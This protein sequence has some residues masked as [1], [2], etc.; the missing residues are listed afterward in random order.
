MAE[1]DR[2]SG[3]TKAL[4]VIGSP[5]GHSLSPAMHNLTYQKLGLD[6]VYLAFDV[7]PEQL[8][9]VIPAMK[10]MGFVG[11]NV[12]MPCKTPILP[13]LDELSDAARLMN[14]VN[15]VVI[16]DGRAYGHNTD[17]AGFMRNLKENGIDV[18]GSRITIA[19][20][21]GAGSAILTQAALDGV[22]VIEVF[23]TRDELFEKLK[24]RVAKLAAE[25]GCAI[26]VHDRSDQEALGR[27]VAESSLFV[28]AT[29]TGMGPL[30]D[31]SVL[32]A[33]FLHPDL[34]VADAVYDPP[35]TKMLATAQA[36]GNV[37]ISGLGMLLWQAAIAEELFV[38]AAMPVDYVA[39][40]VFP[41]A[42][43]LSQRRNGPQQDLQ[44]K[45]PAKEATREG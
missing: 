9:T 35:V 38:G 27:C 28:N 18:C 20:A 32:P 16:K 5:V 29:K 7:K 10:M 40:R 19:G 12:T 41:E 44:G 2:I 39:E 15:T 11:A 1:K 23:K 6:Y 26:N 4:A 42:G 13:Y 45:G 37:T 14:A 25:T 33:E 34:I 24:R 3:R 30:R 22:G 36:C 31:Q 8:E 17:G 43:L 21:G